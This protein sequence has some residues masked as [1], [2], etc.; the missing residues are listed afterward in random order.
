[1]KTIAYIDLAN[2]STFYD[3][4]GSPK[5]NHHKRILEGLKELEHM[6]DIAIYLIKGNKYRLIKVNRL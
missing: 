6:G 4:K 5:D 2:K 1:M 3:F